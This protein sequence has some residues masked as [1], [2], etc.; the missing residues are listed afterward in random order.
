[1][2]WARRAGNEAP[3]VPVALRRE[4]HATALAL[5]IGD[6]AGAFPLA[7]V[8]GELTGLADRA[9]DA[10][11]TDAIRAEAPEGWHSLVAVGAPGSMAD[12]VIVGALLL[13]PA[14]IEG[15]DGSELATALAIGPVAVL[16][17]LQYRGIGS[18][19]M[20][21]AMG[22][23][24]A[25]GVPALVLLGHDTYYPRFGFVAARGVGL[26]PPTEKWPDQFWMA[27]LLPAWDDDFQG[28]VRF[29][30]AFGPLA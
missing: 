5:A 15:D 21:A 14:P 8:V 18:A 29:H 19:L 20:G 24:I 7:R 25:R 16:P 12:G 1:L 27:K 23:A 2:A 13:S 3:T 26:Q 17:E 6:L 4:R 30:E 22:L 10:A 28:T 11:I 9:L